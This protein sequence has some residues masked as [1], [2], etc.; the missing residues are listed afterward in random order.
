MLFPCL[1]SLFPGL[2]LKRS[3]SYI[4]KTQKIP[5][6]GVTDTP[7]S[8]S[9]VS[10]QIKQVDFLPTPSTMD[11]LKKWK[12]GVDEEEEEEEV[13]HLGVSTTPWIRAHLVPLHRPLRREPQPSQF[14]AFL[15]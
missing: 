1:K 8:P 12:L 7:I 3:A 4:S 2:D 13:S 15:S 6:Q 5:F 9:H 11:K 14:I 10:I